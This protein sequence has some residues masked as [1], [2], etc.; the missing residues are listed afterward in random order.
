MIHLAATFGDPTSIG[1][2][3]GTAAI[4]SFLRKH[5]Q[6]HIHVFAPDQFQF[7]HSRVIW[8]SQPSKNIFTPGHPGRASGAQA[9][10]DLDNAIEACLEKKCDALVTGPVDKYW[11]SKTLPK[12]T[13][14]TGHLESKT[15]SAGTTML[16]E[17]P[18]LR[19]SLVTV[20][21]SLKSISAAL[22]KERIQETILRTHEYLAAFIENPRIAVCALNP[23]ASDRGLMGDEEKKLISPAIR[24]ISKTGLRIEG[25]FAADS[26]F[27]RAHEFDAIVCMYHDQGLIPLKMRYFDEAVNI[28]LGLPFLRTSVDHGTAFDIAGMAKAKSISYGQALEHAFR[29]VNRTGGKTPWSVQHSL[30]QSARRQRT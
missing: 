18:K 13:G 1:P 22:T 7:K 2:E 6:V 5:S 12:F 8:H 23:H 27:H 20:H 25:P 21:L 17:A 30:D 14:H 11:C 29:W 15:K 4:R 24:S 28:T 9:L 26:L 16:L 3:V 19:V 10:R